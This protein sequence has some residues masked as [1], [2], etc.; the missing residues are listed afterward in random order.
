MLT[1]DHLISLDKYNKIL[2]VDKEARQVTVQAGIRLWQLA[3]E[4]EKYGLAFQNLGTIKKQS[5]AGAIST[6]TH[7]CI[8]KHFFTSKFMTKSNMKGDRCSS[9]GVF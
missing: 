6:G 8:S 2:N 7:V 3:D 5:I 1:N 4:L 9:F